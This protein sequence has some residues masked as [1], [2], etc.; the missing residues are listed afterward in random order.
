MR[1]LSVLWLALFPPSLADTL[2][3]DQLSITWVGAPAVR[4]KHDLLGMHLR[5]DRDD[6]CRPQIETEES[7]LPTARHLSRLIKLPSLSNLGGARYR[8]G[9]SRGTT[10]D[11]SP[12][13]TTVVARCARLVVPAHVSRRK[14]R[15]AKN[16]TIC[17][18]AFTMRFYGPARCWR[19]NFISKLAPADVQI[20]IFNVIGK[21]RSGDKENPWA[22]GICA[23][24]QYFTMILA[25]VIFYRRVQVSREDIIE[26]VKSYGRSSSP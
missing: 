2:H 1:P 4:C 5:P 8:E 16:E 26:F 14:F 13:P 19:R 7:R 23:S 24:A 12:S 18:D 21:G 17:P 9:S 22:G 3:T 10:N 15:L 20:L 25:T 11:S 6:S